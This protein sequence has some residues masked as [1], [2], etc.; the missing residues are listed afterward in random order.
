MVASMNAKWQ[1]KYVIFPNKN[2]SG[3]CI[4]LIKDGDK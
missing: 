1:N 4:A 2:Y 3:L